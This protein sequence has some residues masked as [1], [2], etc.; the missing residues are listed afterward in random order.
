MQV[1]WDAG[2]RVG[3]RI[4][5]EEGT[6]DGKWCC[7]AERGAMTCPGSHGN[8]RHQEPQ[9]ICRPGCGDGAQSTEPSTAQAQPRSESFMKHHKSPWNRSCPSP[10][11]FPNCLTAS[12][13]LQC[14]FIKLSAES[15]AIA[16]DFPIGATGHLPPGSLKG[17]SRCRGLTH[18]LHTNFIE[19]SR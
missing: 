17:Q 16:L 10:Q 7:K 19:V 9:T 18:P 15:D 11:A 13:S 1:W 4:L 14:L 12:A 5:G 8:H 2:R 3:S 6:Q